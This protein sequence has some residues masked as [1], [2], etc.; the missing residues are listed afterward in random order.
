DGRPDPK[1]TDELTVNMECKSCMTQLV[2]TILLPCG[3]AILCRWC[4]AQHISSIRNDP[5]RPKGNVTCP[6][7]RKSVKQK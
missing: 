4:A 7:C 3:H 2:D 6:L 1:E 5:T